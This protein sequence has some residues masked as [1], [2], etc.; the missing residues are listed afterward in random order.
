MGS[1]EEMARLDQEVGHRVIK[2]GES[3]A[4]RNR[5]LSC[6]AGTE[7][8]WM[9]QTRPARS[10]SCKSNQKHG[11]LGSRAKHTG[12]L[13]DVTIKEEPPKKPKDLAVQAQSALVSVYLNPVSARARTTG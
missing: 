2:A 12:R 9:Q 1:T 5:V 6:H 11:A 3:A 4:N 10:R 7:K 8:S 13:F